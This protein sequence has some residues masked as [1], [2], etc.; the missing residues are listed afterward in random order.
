MYMWLGSATMPDV[1]FH[2]T[3]WPI[4]HSCTLDKSC[5]KLATETRPGFGLKN[6]PFQKFHWCNSCCLHMTTV[7][8]HPQCNLMPCPWGSLKTTGL[9]PTMHIFSPGRRNIILSMIY[10]EL[11][12]SLYQ[13][14]EK[15]V[16]LSLEGRGKQHKNCRF[17]VCFLKP[18][19]VIL[20]EICNIW[21]LPKVP[22]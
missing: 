12:K 2:S 14:Q 8:L 22:Y 11:L 10:K 16:L 20:I 17:L 1:H 9:N 15:L 4:L 21:G 18:L 7:K 3:S 6:F 13:P 19:I 5:F